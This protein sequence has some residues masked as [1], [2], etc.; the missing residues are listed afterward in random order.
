MSLCARGQLHQHV[1][2]QLLQAQI[3]KAQTDT[4][5]CQSFLHF[6]NLR[7][8]AARKHVGEIDPRFQSSTSA[9]GQR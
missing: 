5:K 1:Y 4:V 8:K 6:W 2:L 9:I 3:L 7:I